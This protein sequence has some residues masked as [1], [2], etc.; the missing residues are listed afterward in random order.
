MKNIRNEA[1]P[2]LD[3]NL[4]AS[5]IVSSLSVELVNSIIPYLP[6]KCQVHLEKLKKLGD[7]KEPFLYR[8]LCFLKSEDEGILVGFGVDEI[9]YLVAAWNTDGRVDLWEPRVAPDSSPSNNN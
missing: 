6:G 2:T 7:P 5:F 8:F 3:E 1:P 9:Y 4:L